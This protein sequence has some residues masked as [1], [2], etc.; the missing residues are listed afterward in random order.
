MMNDDIPDDYPL[1]E[2]D[3]PTRVITRGES[4][5]EEVMD[6]GNM[7]RLSYLLEQKIDI[8]K[9][10]LRD[11]RGKVIGALGQSIVGYSDGLSVQDII[12]DIKGRKYDGDGFAVSAFRRQ[13]TDGF[14]FQENGNRYFLFLRDKNKSHKTLRDEKAVFKIPLSHQV[15]GL[16]G[17][18]L[19]LP[20]DCGLCIPEGD[21]PLLV[22]GKASLKTI[23]GE[24]GCLNIHV[25][26]SDHILNPA[27]NGQQ[28]NRVLG[29]KMGNL[30]R[31]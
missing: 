5:Y 26:K 4:R 7:Y 21:R 6:V 16:N 20:G 22:Y 8:D 14:T 25:E 27:Y 12:Q 30:P 15:P 11:D 31:P 18:R 2:D 29:L 1:I 9:I 17:M 23:N 24:N 3:A 19:I 28:F 10:G 13:T